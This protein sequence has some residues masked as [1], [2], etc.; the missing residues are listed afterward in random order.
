MLDLDDLEARREKASEDKADLFDFYNKHWNGL[1]DRLRDLE[2]QDAKLASDLA[3][4]FPGLRD[5]ETDVN[6]GD[7]VEWLSFRFASA[8]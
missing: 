7:L 1:I 5:G 6:G 2:K 8:T 4:A 3:E